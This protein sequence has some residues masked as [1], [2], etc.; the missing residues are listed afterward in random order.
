[1]RSN[2]GV[3]IQSQ[4]QTQPQAG[5]FLESGSASSFYSKIGANDKKSILLYIIGMVFILLIFWVGF[6]RIILGQHSYNQIILGYSWSLTLC[7]TFWCAKNQILKYLKAKD[8]AVAKPRS[9][10]LLL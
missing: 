3:Q 9:R 5:S 10:W 2:R 7:L 8:R 1:M 6:S 4:P